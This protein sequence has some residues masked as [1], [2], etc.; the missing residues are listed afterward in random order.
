MEIFIQWYINKISIFIFN[1]YLSNEKWTG[2]FR[3]RKNR[4]WKGKNETNK[5]GFHSNEVLLMLILSLNIFDI[6]I[7]TGKK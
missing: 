6:R 2:G 4:E 5:K 3:F 7:F 1:R